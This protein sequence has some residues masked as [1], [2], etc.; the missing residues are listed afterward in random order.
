MNINLDK[1]CYWQCERTH[2]LCLCL[3]AVGHRWYNRSDNNRTTMGTLF[4][5]LYLFIHY[6]F[7]IGHPSRAYENQEKINNITRRPTTVGNTWTIETK[8]EPNWKMKGSQWLTAKR[9]YAF[10]SSIPF[11]RQTLLE[12]DL[13][14]TL[15]HRTDR[16]P[17]SIQYSHFLFPLILQFSNWLKFFHFTNIVFQLGQMTKKRPTHCELSN[18]R[19]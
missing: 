3:P 13:D 16:N 2:A 8:T 19:H 15:V 10:F 7:V 18:N 17:A 1:N 14:D 4:T 9:I 6:L 12:I 11:F 5:V